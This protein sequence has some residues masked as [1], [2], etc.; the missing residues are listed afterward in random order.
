MVDFATVSHRMDSYAT[1]AVLVALVCVFGA[2]CIPLSVLI[3]RLYLAA[4]ALENARKMSVLERFLRR[5]KIAWAAITLCTG[6]AMATAVY[7]TAVG[8]VMRIR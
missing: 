5:Q 7:V 3:A 6:M 1:F 2:V 8:V 4:K